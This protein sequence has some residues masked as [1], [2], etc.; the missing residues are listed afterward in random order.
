MYIPTSLPGFTYTGQ[1][2]TELRADW[3]WVIRFKTSGTLTITDRNRKV[4]VFLVGGGGGGAQNWYSSDANQGGGGGGYTAMQTGIPA[5]A[6]TAYSIVIGAGG[7]A[8]GST[9][10]TGGTSSAFGLSASGG[11]GGTKSGSCGTGGAGGSGGGNGGQNGGSNGSSAGGT[12]AG[13][14]TYEFRTAGWPLYAGGGGGGRSAGG[15]GGG[16]DGG[17]RLI[18]GEYTSR[19]GKNG[20]ANT[21]GGGGGAGP[22]GND[23]DGEHPGGAGGSGIVCIRNS[24]DDFLPVKFNDTQLTHMTFNGETVTGLIY[25]GTRIFADAL[26]QMRQRLAGRMRAYGV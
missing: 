3:G 21:G 6:G 7:S 23:P 11:K 25:N 15:A 20:T 8:G 19:P 13:V 18:N 9:G 26:R 16:G 10:G 2:S 12:G 1:Y 17:Y 5:Q 4:D 22:Q 14:S 24:A